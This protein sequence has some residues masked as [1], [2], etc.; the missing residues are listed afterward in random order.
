MSA[1]VSYMFSGHNEVPWHKTNYTCIEGTATSEEA[2]HLAHID[3]DVVQ[4]AVFTAEG[5]A[6][7]RYRFNRKS[8]DG[9]VIGLVTDRYQVVQNTEAFAFTDALIGKGCR[10]ETAGA[11]DNWR[12]VW[13]L[14]ALEPKNIMGDTFNNY[15]VFKNS[16]DGKSAVKVC[17]TPVRVV[18]QNTLNC[19]L[20]GAKRTFSMKHVGVIDK[21]LHQADEVLELS[22]N[23]LT[24]VEKAYYDLQKIKLSEYKVQQLIEQLF[25]YPTDENT[26]KRITDNIQG[27]RSQLLQCYAKDD[28]ANF[29]GTGYGFVNAV[30]DWAG[31]ATPLRETSGYY[32]NLFDKVTNGH[33]ILDKAYELVTAL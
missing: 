5:T 30:S 10:Y 31:H 25:P 21:K 24:Q 27:Q 22:K 4:E 6:V 19:A 28:L 11:L 14:A 20:S 26:T 8:D 1:N 2:L 32:G 13:M 9:T 18:C 23:Y 16:H 33:P 12:T 7:D 29:R 15:L 3:Y 17:V